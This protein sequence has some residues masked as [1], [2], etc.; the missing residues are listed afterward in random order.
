MIKSS[1]YAAWIKQQKIEIIWKRHFFVKTG[2]CNIL[3]K[4]E[5]FGKNF[6]PFALLMKNLIKSQCIWMG[7]LQGERALLRGIEYLL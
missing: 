1:E 4:C 3:Q 2:F 6:Q 5:R 7:P